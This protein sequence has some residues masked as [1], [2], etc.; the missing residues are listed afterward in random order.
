M[1][2]DDAAPRADDERPLVQHCPFCGETIGSFWGRRGVD[3]SA[4]CESCALGFR[5]EL[6]DGL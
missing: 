6:T 4:W 3:D 2:E 5:V 1:S